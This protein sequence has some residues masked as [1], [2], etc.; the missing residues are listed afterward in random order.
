MVAF[1]PIPNK[2]CDHHMVF[3]RHRM[4]AERINR[5]YHNYSLLDVGCRTM[6]L[7]SLLNNCR[8]YHGTD[9]TPGDGIFECNLE[10]KLP[11]DD[12]SFDIVTALDVLEH[13]DHPHQA[14]RELYR[15]ARQAVFISLPNIHY[16]Q[17]RVRFLFG[18]G[19]SG[20]YVFPVQPIV[21]RHRWVL[22]YQEALRFVSMNADGHAVHCE[23]I[24]PE[25]IWI[26]GIPRS[27]EKW[28]GNRWPD[29][30]AYGLLCEIRL[31]Q[32]R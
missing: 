20:K 23:M 2:A 6:S 22:S 28:L 32:G 25:R 17:F 12:R 16:A 10:E 27:V 14:L 8:Q 9:R 19:L 3:T 7:R 11:F 1:P 30:F 21:D 4:C 15:V 13:L 29:L 5:Q 26:R 18:R 31:N 24:L